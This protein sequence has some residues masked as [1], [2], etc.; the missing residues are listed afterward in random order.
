MISI[1]LLTFALFGTLGLLAGKG[2]KGQI[3][4]LALGLLVA[5]VSTLLWH[6]VLDGFLEHLFVFENA[7]AVSYGGV[8]AATFSYLKWKKH[9]ANMERTF[10][11]QP[12]VDFIAS[13]LGYIRGD[14]GY[15]WISAFVKG[16]IITLPLGGLLGGTAFMLGHEIGSHAE[17]RVEKYGIDPRRIID[18]ISYGLV[19]VSVVGTVFIVR[20]LVGV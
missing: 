20:A 3:P 11:L 7:L 12:V 5:S 19:G 15:S 8:Q 13:K 6:P 4:E 9:K 16:F 10:T 18:V 14:E 2:W 17:D 1:L